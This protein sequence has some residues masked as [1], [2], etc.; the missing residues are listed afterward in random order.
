MLFVS[1]GG[2]WDPESKLLVEQK[3][4]IHRET[5]PPVRLIPHVPTTSTF[6]LEETSR[7]DHLNL[8]FC[9]FSV[10]LIFFW[11]GILVQIVLS[12]REII[13]C[14]GGKWPSVSSFQLQKNNFTR[15][16]LL[17]VCYRPFKILWDSKRH[18]LGSLSSMIPISEICKKRCVSV[19]THFVL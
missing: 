8:T 5:L 6:Q 4:K 18:R 12:Q 10:L 19:T 17:T 13:N 11:Q 9:G 15:P 7:C 14:P 1:S 2:R 16:W 3:S